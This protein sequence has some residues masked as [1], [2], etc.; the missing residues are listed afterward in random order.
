[1]PEAADGAAEAAEVASSSSVPFASDAGLGDATEAMGPVAVERQPA[2][3]VARARAAMATVA[4][5]RRRKRIVIVGPRDQWF[6]TREGF[7]PD[8]DGR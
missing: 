1:E 3:G 5:G 7:E 8:G 2:C 4:S 6:A